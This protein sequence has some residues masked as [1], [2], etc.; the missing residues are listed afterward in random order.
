MAHIPLYQ[1]L[2][3]RAVTKRPLRRLALLLGGAGIPLALAGSALGSGFLQGAVR[4]TANNFV[5]LSPRGP[6]AVEA[7]GQP[8]VAAKPG[9]VAS[10]APHPAASLSNA[11]FL[12]PPA[13][14]RLPLEL[15]AVIAPAPVDKPTA[16][17]AAESTP[18]AAPAKRSAGERRT[19]GPTI[20]TPFRRR[21]DGASG[22]WSPPR[23]PAAPDNAKPSHESSAPSNDSQ[24]GAQAYSRHG[25]S[26]R[27]GHDSSKGSPSD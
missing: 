24:S 16:V 9:P 14:V 11:A 22:A 6:G 13:G 3:R 27:P 2:I 21:S 12:S 15:P 26:S 18:S 10:A 20:G 23:P 25:D 5:D 8:W 17:P 4:G 7:L 1:P 19:V